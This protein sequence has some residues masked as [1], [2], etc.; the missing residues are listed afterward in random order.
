M[1]PGRKLRDYASAG[2]PWY[3]LAE[4]DMVDYRSITLRL[5]RLDGARYTEQAVASHGEILK[6]D[7]PFPFAIDP[8]DLV[9]P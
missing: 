7:A 8:T 2:I 6:S 4:P 5:Y 1:Q 9:R 3:L